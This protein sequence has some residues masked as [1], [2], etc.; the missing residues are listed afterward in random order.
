MRRNDREVTDF[1]E[2][3]DILKRADTLHLGIFGEEFPYVV[4]L[5]YGFETSDGKIVFY[6]H[7]ASEGKKHDLISA[8]SRIC[9]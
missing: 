8:D 4:P 3:V 1:N 2:I 9:A 5:S 7:G 6:V